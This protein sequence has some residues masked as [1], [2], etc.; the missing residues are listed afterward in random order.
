MFPELHLVA[1]DELAGSF[2]ER[3][4]Y[5]HPGGKTERPLLCLPEHVAYIV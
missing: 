4:S 2:L 1:S 3:S 5:L